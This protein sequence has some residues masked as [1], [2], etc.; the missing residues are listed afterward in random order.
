MFV[1]GPYLTQ[2]KSSYHLSALEKFFVE[3]ITHESS[4]RQVREVRLSGLEQGLNMS[5][6]N[7]S[8]DCETTPFSLEPMSLAIKSFS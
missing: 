2:K 8:I 3:G 6:T 5:K 4:R 1:R 7:T